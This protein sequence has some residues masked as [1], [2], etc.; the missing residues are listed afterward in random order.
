MLQKQLL[1]FAGMTAAI[2]A[3][4]VFG[5]YVQWG[6]PDPTPADTADQW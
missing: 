4:A 3:C 6:A 1:I 5:L 2:V